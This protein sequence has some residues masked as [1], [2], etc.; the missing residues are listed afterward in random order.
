MGYAFLTAE[1]LVD[2]Y[3]ES[4]QVVRSYADVCD[5]GVE[6]LPAPRAGYAQ[7]QSIIR[8]CVDL[9]CLLSTNGAMI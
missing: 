9:V 7:T 6:P 1:L 2:A 3:N 5:W 4:G 8:E